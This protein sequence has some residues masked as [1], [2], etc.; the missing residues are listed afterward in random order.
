MKKKK[1]GF[2]SK[3][4][5][6][7][8]SC[9]SSSSPPSFVDNFSEL[10]LHFLQSEGVVEG[11][12]RRALRD[13][14]EDFP[15]HFYSL[16]SLSP[17]LFRLGFRSLI[18]TNPSLFNQNNNYFPLEI[19]F[20]FFLNSICHSYLHSSLGTFA[21]IVDNSTLTSSSS[22]SFSS[23]TYQHLFLKMMDII[24]F[25]SVEV[26]ELITPFLDFF[27]H[28]GAC[29]RFQRVFFL[30]VFFLNFIC[31]CLEQ[32]LVIFF[33][34]LYFILFSFSSSFFLFFNSLPFFKG[35]SFNSSFVWNCGFMFSF[36]ICVEANYL[37][38][39]FATK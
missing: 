26:K 20:S 39:H 22:F 21:K 7:S 4:L 10:F 1:G 17:V 25:S 28:V 5:P 27:C 35:Y 16:C 24:L 14:R 11:I 37:R 31:T 3:P 38:Y 6:S 2:M 18:P 15:R 29:F 13:G 33:P 34:F 19:H 8:S 36:C 30:K 12:W 23:S 9:S 32:P